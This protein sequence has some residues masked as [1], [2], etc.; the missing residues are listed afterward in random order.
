[1]GHNQNSNLAQFGHTTESSHNHKPHPQVDRI[2]LKPQKTPLNAHKPEPIADCR[3][4]VVIAHSGKY[5]FVVTKRREAVGHN[6]FTA[7]NERL[8]AE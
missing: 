2:E 4:E 5:A 3:D 1:M 6:Q 8:Q 7:N